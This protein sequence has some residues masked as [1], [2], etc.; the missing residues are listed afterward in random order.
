MQLTDPYL[1]VVATSN[2]RLRNFLERGSELRDAAAEEA[3]VNE[4]EGE[5]QGTLV[6]LKKFGRAP[7]VSADEDI[8]RRSHDHIA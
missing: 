4:D 2:A 3:Q 7:N 1:S 6:D 8:V 5:G